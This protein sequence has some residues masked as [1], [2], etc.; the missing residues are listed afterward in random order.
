MEDEKIKIEMLVHDLK[1]PL[2]VIEAGVRGMMERPDSYGPLTPKQEK[3][4]RRLLRNTRITQQMVGDALELGRC[5]EGI[6]TAGRFGV[7]DWLEG[8]LVEI[9]DLVENG[10]SEQIHADGDLAALTATLSRKGLILDVDPAVWEATLHTD[11]TKLTQ[12]LR[13][14]LF[15][16]FKYRKERVTLEIRKGADDLSLSVQDDG[17]GIPPEMHD[18]IFECYFQADPADVSSARGHGL[19]LAAAMVMAEALGGRL[20]LESEGGRG[21]RFHVRLPLTEPG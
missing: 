12:I 21:A 3:V 5:R 20:R 14:L 8:V 19:G 11:R 13:N 4:L 16:A 7:A 17:K 6:V 1:T 9:F 15:N 10:V 2:A 18:K